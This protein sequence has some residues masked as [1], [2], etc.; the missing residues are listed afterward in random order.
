MRVEQVARQAAESARFQAGVGP[1]RVDVFGAIY[2]LKFHLLRYPL[3]EGSL[4]GA[5]LR[6]DQERFILVNSASVRTRQRFTAAHEL[7]HAYLGLADGVA[8]YDQTLFDPEDRK[9]NLFAGHFLMDEQSARA[10]TQR[11]RD[12]VRMALVVMADFD[13]SLD[14]AAI[15][16]AGLGMIDQTDKRKLLELS[17][18]RSV[19]LAD[20]WRQH[21]LAA[22]RDS[23]ADRVVDPGSDYRRAL[24]DL[25]RT[26]LLSDEQYAAMAF[27]QQAVR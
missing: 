19:R 6:H 24:H 7:G 25:H 2:T 20:L 15:H 23:R 17:N 12:P 21:G 10:L 4:E 13:V 5:F 11:E 16:L 18:D 3:P 26:G 9:A 8:H 27:R 22:P 1:G 14:A